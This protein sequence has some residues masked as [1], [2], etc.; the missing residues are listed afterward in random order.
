LLQHLPVMVCTTS[1]AK[2]TTNS[3]DRSATAALPPIL[4]VCAAGEYDTSQALLLRAV[5][6]V[7]AESRRG[8]EFKLWMAQALQGGGDLPGAIAV[9]K[10]MKASACCV[11]LV[12]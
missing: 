5:T 3:M 9:L 11:P 8:G 4:S 10:T 6:F 1:D 7:G 2:N 12:Q